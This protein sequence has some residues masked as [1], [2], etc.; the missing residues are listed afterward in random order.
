MVGKALDFLEPG[1]MCPPASSLYAKII[2]LPLEFYINLS[3]HSWQE[4][5]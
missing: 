4:N 2:G 1:Y 3:S 5:K